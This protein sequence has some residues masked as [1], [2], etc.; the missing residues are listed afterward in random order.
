VAI[1]PRAHRAPDPHGTISVNVSLVLIPVTVTDALQHPQLGLQ[2]EAF[3]LFED[4][5]EQ[6]V[7]SLAIEHAPISLGIVFD[8]SGS[9][10][11]KMTEAR[12]AVEQMLDTSV[13]GDEFLLIDFNNRPRLVSDFTG[14]PEEIRTALS[15][16][17]PNGWTAL[18]DA[19]YLAVNQMKHANNSRKAVLVLSDGA[20]NHSRYRQGELRAL[21]RESEVSLYAVGILGQGIGA[22]DMKL[23]SGFAE[24]TGGRLFTADGLRELPDTIDKVNTALREQYVLGYRPTNR[25]KDGKFRRVQVKL[26]TAPDSPPLR[27]SWRAGYYAPD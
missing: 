11:R 2:R 3:R 18:I 4:G 24:D 22:K 8:S 21:L 26:N 20:D 7:E 16:I 10:T 25:D 13:P 15:D 14:S 27:A 9:M 12:Q 6:N 5:V 17:R 1:G 23:L 19:I